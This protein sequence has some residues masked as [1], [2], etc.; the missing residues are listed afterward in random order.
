MVILLGART[1][2]LGTLLPCTASDGIRVKVVPECVD[3]SPKLRQ[4]APGTGEE[5]DM[6]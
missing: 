6:S 5:V 2:P 1:S 3:Q 4:F